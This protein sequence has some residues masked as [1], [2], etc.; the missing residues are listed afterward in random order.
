VSRSSSRE[1][2]EKAFLY[3][4]FCAGLSCAAGQACGG[5]SGDARP[6]A[7]LAATPEATQAFAAIQ[8]AWDAADGTTP[9]ALRPKLEAFVATYPKDGRAA[10]ARAYLAFEQTDVGDWAAAERTLATLRAVMPGT[11]RDVVTIAE[12]R[13]LRHDKQPDAALDALRPL[14]GKIVDATVRELFIEEITRAALESR[15]DFEA[16]AYMDAWLRG[17]GEDKRE[18]AQAKVEAELAKLPEPV[19]EQTYRAMRSNRSVLGYG[20]DTQRLIAERLAATAITRG[21]PTLAR[22]LL[23]ADAGPSFVGGDAGVLLGEIATSK[24]GLTSFAGR[25]VGL[26]LPTASVDL[27]DEAADVARGVAWSL[28]LPRMDPKAGDSVQLV[29]RDDGGDP[30]RTETALEELAGEGAGVIV[31]ALDTKTA[32]RALA[33]GEAHQLTVIALSAP[34]RTR[35]GAGAGDWGFVLGQSRDEE[36]SAIADLLAARSV[37]KAAVV[38]SA[39]TTIL[40]GRGFPLFLPLVSCDVEAQQAGEPR[41]PLASWAK[42]GARVVVVAGPVECAR[43]VIRELGATGKP[44]TVALTLD[45]GSTTAR[46]AG[47][48][49]VAVTAGVVPVVAARATEVSDP[50]VRAY[51]TQF[52]ARP[53]WWTALGRDGGTLARAALA[54]LP[55]DTLADP[56]A[57]A[58]RRALVQF[59]VAAAVAPLWTTEATGFAGAHVMKRKIRVIDLPSAGK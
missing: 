58:Q 5:G 50:D 6:V 59:R 29:T 14:V 4:L 10:L 35:A 48:S 8:R 39:P 44:A 32:E 16:V 36:L 42:Q 23:D 34:E 7:S 56:A 40:D 15:R 18:R 27:R 19:L 3:V 26:L 9:G 17:V 41:F 52:G 38:G 11:T 49:L 25:T 47:V 53:S 13:M 22:W 33:W 20:A 24:R 1:R 51:M 28:G 12:A 55:L 2:A 31:A 30:A 54:A 46:A 57:I 21:D 37:A 45:D 43:D